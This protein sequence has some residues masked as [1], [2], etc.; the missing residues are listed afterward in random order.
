MTGTTFLITIAIGIILLVVRFI[1]RP[2]GGHSKAGEPRTSADPAKPGV[3]WRD[4]K[5]M[6]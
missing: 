1:I 2:I 4:K 6:E 3:A 5:G